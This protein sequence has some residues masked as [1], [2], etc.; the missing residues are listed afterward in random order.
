MT[1][2][3]CVLLWW[4][5]STAVLHSVSAGGAY[6]AKTARA[7]AAALGLKYP[8]VHG[9]PDFSSPA[10]HLLPPL[11]FSFDHLPP[12]ESNVNSY[13]DDHK[14]APSDNPH[15]RDSGLLDR[16]PESSLEEVNHVALPTL[17]KASSRPDP[18]NLHPQ[19]RRK[20]FLV[21]RSKNNPAG[22]EFAP[23]R[24][25]MP[26]TGHAPLLTWGHT[27]YQSG[28]NPK[29]PLLHSARFLQR[30]RGW[31]PV[32]G[33]WKVVKHP[34][35]LAKNLHGRVGVRPPIQGRAILQ[36]LGKTK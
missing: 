24:R 8:G 14:K 9:A 12:T 11:T 15:A 27:A 1:V 20:P 6:C 2:Q 19:G 21:R 4:L 3:K 10:V 16:K 34:D 7:R 13:E 30:Q 25:G 35:H 28:I 31:A 18:M 33:F 29:V 36:G 23:N 22:D 5:L 17:A 26:L 32:R